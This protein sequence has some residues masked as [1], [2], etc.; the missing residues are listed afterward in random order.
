MKRLLGKVWKP[1]TSLAVLVILW[2]KIDVDDAMVTIWDARLGPLLSGLIIFLLAQIV[3]SQRYIFAMQTLN[4]KIP[5]FLALR[6]HF[7]G[8]WFS[9][10]LPSGIG[11]DVV[12]IFMLKDRVGISKAIRGTLLDRVS[13][14]IFLMVGVVLLLPAYQLELQN[15]TVTATLTALATTFFLVLWGGVHFNGNRTLKRLTPKPLRHISLLL[16]DVARFRH[17]K[18]LMQQLWTSAVVHTGG[19]LGYALIGMSLGIELPILIYY[20]LVPLIF[21]ISLIPISFG[22]WGIREASS[23]G[24]FGLVGLPPEQAF[25]MSVLFGLVVICASLPGGILLLFSSRPPHVERGV[26]LSETQV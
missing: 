8:L 15:F 9:Q 4:R 25:A 7:V 26:D 14:L 19:I 23:I 2:N 21:L 18:P 3:S 1:L 16:N 13:G 10:L 11:G 17:R 12:K 6:V 24:L 20:L 5:F 22:G